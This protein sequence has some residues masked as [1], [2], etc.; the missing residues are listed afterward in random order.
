MTD[1]A[2]AT[3]TL[4]GPFRERSRVLPLYDAWDVPMWQQYIRDLAIFGVNAIE[5]IPPRSDDAANSPH[6]PL[7]PLRMM[8]EMSR[9]A[10]EYGLDVWCGIRSSTRTTAI[11]RRRS[12]RS[13]SG[14]RCCR[15]CR[16]RRRA[17]RSGRR[18]R[19]HASRPHVPAAR[20]ADGQP[21]PVSAAVADV[22]GSR[23]GSTPNG[24]TS[25]TGSSGPSRPGSPASCSAHRCAIDYPSRYRGDATQQ[26]RMA[27]GAIRADPGRPE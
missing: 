15:S 12:S 3:K 27:T 5:L 19:A 10:D 17:V 16:A 25:S 24:W 8:S 6:F 7:P 23:R 18:P 14:P 4:P 22:D 13:T 26:R 20:E 1:A 9:L 21:A 11:P 2:T